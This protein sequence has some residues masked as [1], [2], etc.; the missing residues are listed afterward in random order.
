[1]HEQNSINIVTK[2]AA[3][4]EQHRVKPLLSEH[5][6]TSVYPAVCEQLS[7]ILIKFE[8]FYKIIINNNNN[9]KIIIVI[10]VTARP[11]GHQPEQLHNGTM[12]VHVGNCN[13]YIYI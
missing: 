1:M 13:I 8:Y 10:M 3:T 5:M 12:H 4:C 11:I 7:I 2:K 9:F 6:G